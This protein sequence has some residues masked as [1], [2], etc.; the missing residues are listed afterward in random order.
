MTPFFVIAGIVTTILG[1]LAIVAVGAV[2]IYVRVLGY[3][4]TL[5][6]EKTPKKWVSEEPRWWRR[7][8]PHRHQYDLVEHNGKKYVSD[9]CSICG[10]K[11]RK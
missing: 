10:K 8:I 1:I 9:K 7:F 5:R 4:I 11:R 2:I 3:P 6:Y